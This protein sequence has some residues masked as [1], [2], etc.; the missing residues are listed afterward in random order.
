MQD[1]KLGK[2][3]T[4]EEFC[5]C[6]QTYHKYASHINPF[7]KNTSEV[8]PSLQDLNKFILDPIID[9]FGENKFC[10]TYGFCS[11][12]LKKYLE[13][14]DPITGKK[15]GRVAPNIDQH[16]SYEMNK[17]GKYYCERLGAACDFII[18]DTASQEVIDWILAFLLPFD[19]LYFYGKDKPIHISYGYQHKRDIWTF[20]D[21]GIPTKKGI[22]HWVNLAK[23]VHK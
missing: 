14:K 7:P 1:L 16:F 6:T 3:L 2:Y 18:K 10:L 8:I 11:I 15:N 17:N 23:L 22:E 20:S 9:Y 21:A 12:D 5:T 4:L 19:S 13:K